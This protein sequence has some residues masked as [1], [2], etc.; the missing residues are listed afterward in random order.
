MDQVRREGPLPPAS[1]DFQVFAKP[2][3]ATCN[4]DCRYCYYLETALPARAQGP[5]RMPDDVLEVYVA[6]HL[7]AAP[8]REVLFSW[9]GG[10]P[11]VLGVEYFRRVVAL[12]RLHRRP[13][14]AI[15]NGLQT[16]GLLIDDAWCRFLAAEGFRVGVS[17]DGPADLHDAYRVTR[18]GGTSHAKAVRA[19]ELLQRHGVPCEVLC[20]VH[21]R[22]VREPARVYR[23]LKKLGAR[24][25][26]F[27]PLVRPVPGAAGEV[28]AES[29]PAAAYG[30]FLCT[31]FN[32][33]VE[34]DRS[35]V[36]VQAF[37]EATR[38]ARGLPHSLCIYRETCGDV[39]VVEHDGSLYSCD[40]YV[41]A[42]HRLGNICE[43]PLAVL[44]DH[45]SQA[46]FGLAKRDRLPAACR[47]C[48]VLPMC[49]GGC[50]KDRILRT[51]DGE[52]GLNYLC[53][54]LKR[55]F[56][57]VLPYAVQVGLE[58]RGGPSL[59]WLEGDAAATRRIVPAT[60]RNEAC[61]C[62]S[63]RKYK[64]CCGFSSC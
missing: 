9:H 27:L 5:A 24:A 25:I 41:D 28:S 52:E 1:R 31:I 46:A 37:E 43:T 35:R 49:N 53:D 58:R 12:Q 39:A 38:P 13:G 16:N 64:K 3:G 21:D 47:Q 54:G 45:P 61:P 2:A 32:E 8:G 50:P 18:G 10:E 26:G 17:V 56:T 48:P 22:N 57:H 20:V 59:A 29:V 51:A 15:V 14:Q 33:W 23:F 30:D 11:T 62:G 60:G 6:Q 55:F 36:A 44:L 7:E 34:R 42:G 19:F 4:L 63:G 40:H